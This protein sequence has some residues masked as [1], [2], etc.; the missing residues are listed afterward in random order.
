MNSINIEATDFTPTIRF[1]ADGRLFIEGRSLRMYVMDFYKPL[2]DWANALQV[3]FVTFDINLEYVDTGCSKL[4]LKLLKALDE[5]NSIKK[6]I[7]NWH[8]EE[9]DDDALQD[10]QILKEILQKAEFRFHEH[11]ETISIVPDHPKIT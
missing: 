2:I 7:I 11:P 10:G 8:Y 1:G 3:K 9:V 4:L 6:L 5:N